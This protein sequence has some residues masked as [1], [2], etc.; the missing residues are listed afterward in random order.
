MRI[1]T[2]D[3]SASWL[4]ARGLR[5]R[6][7]LQWGSDHHL[8]VPTTYRRLL[9]L[10]PKTPSLQVSLAHQLA[11]WFRYESAF[12]LVNV[13]ASFQPHELEA[14]LSLRRHYGD[15]RWVD[16]VP[17]GATPGHLFS[18]DPRDDRR[19]VRE[20]LIT[21]MAYTFEGYFVQEDGRVILWVADEVIDIAVADHRRLEGPS[22]IVRLPDL[23]VIDGEL[24]PER[25]RHN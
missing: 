8:D 25:I 16:G 24:S 18:D 19:N 2:V 3:E 14:F 4:I 21:M 10:T 7:A 9:F 20:L 22:D 12:L 6:P 11:S 17:G 15:D 23:K 5:L 13:V 1:L